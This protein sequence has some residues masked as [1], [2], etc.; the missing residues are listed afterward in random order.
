MTPPDG[1]QRGAPVATAT[2]ANP[3]Q[4]TIELVARYGVFAAIVAT[5]TAFS[6]LEPDSFFDV[7]TMKSI[8]R[9]AVPLLVVS[10]GITTILVMNKF[11]LSIGGLVSLCATVVV[12]LIS[13]EWVGL[14]VA[15]AILLGLLLGT[16]LGLGVGAAV[17]YFGLPSFILTIALS[18]VYIGLGLEI[19]DSQSVFQ[20]I[21]PSFEQIA[22]GTFL[23]FSNQVYVGLVA[24]AFMY[25]LLQRT[26][27][28]RYMYAIGNNPEAARLSGLPVK[29]LTMLGFGLV[30]FG[31][32]VAGILLT[33]QA[34]AANP[35]TGVGL[36]LP[37]YAAAFLGSSMYRIGIFT[38]LGTALG[39]LYLQ[40]I[41]TGLT[42]LALS[43]PMVQLIQ[44][45][46]LVAAVS[47]ARLVRAKEEE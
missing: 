40:M 21:S 5:F 33:S 3:R 43:G 11:D 23:G 18:T 37:A 20:G 1:D 35:N 22:S 10:L 42:L 16:S 6:L 36:L 2:A 26:E 32:A 13:T 46:I 41:G 31:C 39:A 44:G 25:L 45:A 24:V 9:D 30:G 34:G 12:V 27:M 8:L 38:A 28:G 14:P 19:T 29:R 4:R 47:L 17:A 7:L 15:V